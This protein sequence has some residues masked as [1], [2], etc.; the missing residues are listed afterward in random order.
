[1]TLTAERPLPSQRKGGKEVI[2]SFSPAALKAPFALRCAAFCIDYIILVAVPVVTLLISVSIGGAT[3]SRTGGIS[4]STGWLL[5]SLLWLTN[6]FIL[7]AVNGQ[8][9]G[10]ML[11]G[12]R[13]VKMDGRGISFGT[14]L[15]RNFV[16]YAVT[17]L[18]AGLGFLLSMVGSNGRA[19]HDM[20]AG[21]VV[22]YARK[23]AR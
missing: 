12:L 2:A 4:N 10:K 22:V 5:G 23:R 17:A 1:M 11:T 21:T 20:I 19:L 15:L 16:G 8:S 14:V 18:T 9:I 6:F 13:I 3:T 7:P